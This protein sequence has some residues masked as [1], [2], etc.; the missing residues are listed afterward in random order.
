[1]TPHGPIIM[2]YFQTRMSVSVR[3]VKKGGPTRFESAQADFKLYR[4]GL[5]NPDKYEIQ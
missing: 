2:F 5:K 3:A 4:V 1:M